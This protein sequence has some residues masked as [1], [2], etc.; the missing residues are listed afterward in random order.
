MDDVPK[1]LY[2]PQLVVEM[3]F[4]SQCEKLQQHIKSRLIL[5]NLSHI[6]HHG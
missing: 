5:P 2:C 6:D 1:L 3:F 4:G